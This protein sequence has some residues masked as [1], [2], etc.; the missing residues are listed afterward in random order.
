MTIPKQS[1]QCGRTARESS[2]NPDR[3][4]ISEGATVTGICLD[5]LHVNSVSQSWSGGGQGGTGH[6]GEGKCFKFCAA[7]MDGGV[8]IQDV[9]SLESALKDLKIKY[10][11]RNA[12]LFP[13]WGRRQGRGS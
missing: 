8:N 9:K 2:R 7:G 12:A 4:A 10:A 3:K 1:S 5:S 13:L 6:G 11:V